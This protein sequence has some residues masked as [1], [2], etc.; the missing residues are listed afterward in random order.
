MKKRTDRIG[1]TGVNNQREV[2]KV[3][4]YENNKR[5]LVEFLNNGVRKWTRWDCFMSGSV[6]MPK[7]ESVAKTPTD[8]DAQMHRTGCLITIGMVALGAALI[9]LLIKA[10]L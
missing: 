10:V 7:A 5:V 3:V 6:A 9:G 2:M 8:R 1:V 4:K